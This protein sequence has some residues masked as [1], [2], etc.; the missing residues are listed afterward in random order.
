MLRFINPLN[1]F[2][3]QPK[4]EFDKAFEVLLRYEKS[5]LEGSQK[6]YDL[7]KLLS[8]VNDKEAI[9]ELI[10]A[11]NKVNYSSNTTDWFYFYFP[12]VSHILYFVPI[13]QSEILGYLVGPNFANG[14]DK[15]DE[16]IEIIQGAM[17]FKLKENPNYLTSEGQHWIVNTLPLLKKEVKREIDRCIEEL[18]A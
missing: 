9:D 15:T 10:M 14:I 5:G 13:K 17:K 7:L 16:M 3:T 8:N 12:I 18:N 2:N 1:F 11:L 6:I 4:S